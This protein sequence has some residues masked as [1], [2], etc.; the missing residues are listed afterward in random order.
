MRQQNR[1]SI[2]RNWRGGFADVVGAIEMRVIDA[3]EIDRLVAARDRLA[4]VEQ[5]A[6]PHRLHRGRHADRVV[7]AEN[8]V[9]WRL[10]SRV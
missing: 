9:H 5:H 6:D 10:Q 3:G 1:E 4:L 8:A 2:A 7:I